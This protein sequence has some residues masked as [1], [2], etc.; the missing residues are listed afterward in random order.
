MAELPAWAKELIEQY[1]SGASER[2]LRKVAV[3][4]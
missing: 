1:E 2:L 3:V 4:R